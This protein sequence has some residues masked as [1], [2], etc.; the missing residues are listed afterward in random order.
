MAISYKEIEGIP[1]AE[2]W[3]LA[4]K[5]DPNFASQTAEVTADFF[6]EKG[7]ESLKYNEIAVL[8]DFFSISIRTTFQKID[9]SDARNPLADAGLVEV[10]NTPNGGFVQRIAI[11]SM[12]AISPAYKNLQDGPG[13]DPFVIRKPKAKE[14]FFAQNN[15]YASLLTISD[16]E[17]KTM[18]VNDNGVGEFIAGCMRALDAG[19][20]LQEYVNTKECL[21]A[22]INSTATPLRDTQKLAV[23]SWTSDTAP[24]NEDL[25]SL[26]LTIKDLATAMNVSAQTGAY[27]ANGFKTVVKDDDYVVLMRAGIKNRIQ[28]Q[29]EVGAFNPDRLTIPFKVKEIDDFGGLVP[30]ADSTFETPLYPVYSSLGEQI[31]WAETE[32]AEEATA[33][34]ADVYWK[35]ENSEILAVIAQ[36]GVIFENRQNPYVIEPIRNPRGRY[37]NYWASSPNNSINYDANYNLIV[38]TKPAGA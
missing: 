27:N 10:Y 8:N 14:R 13:P 29:L 25:E 16:F 4:R 17:A 23:D 1:N 15:N 24:A 34:D 36:R 19:Y 32:D 38:I 28:M 18:F 3:N 21:N 30:Y 22:A 6:N 9:V 37:T 12:K 20:T 31:G 26:I 5:A 11:D 35:D 7:F 33:T 2:F